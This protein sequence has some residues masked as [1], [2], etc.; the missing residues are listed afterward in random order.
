MKYTKYLIV[1]GCS[2]ILATSCSPDRMDYPAEGDWVIPGLPQVIS[3]Y[4]GD[5]VTG[6]YEFFKFI[7]ACQVDSGVCVDR[8]MSDLMTFDPPGQPNGKWTAFVLPS[9][10]VNDIAS[11]YFPPSAN[12]DAVQKTSVDNRKLAFKLLQYYFVLGEYKLSDLSGSITMDNG[13]QLAVSPTSITGAEGNTVN[14]ISGDHVARNGIFHIIDGPL[15]ITDTA[16]FVYIPSSYLYEYG[17]D[18]PDKEG[19]NP[20]P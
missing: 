7:Y 3:M 13:V 11:M 1:L 10:Q 5:P 12:F 4:N 18:N 15:H 16:N 14:I 8:Y 20:Y 19:W 2:I 9:A 17:S 6:T